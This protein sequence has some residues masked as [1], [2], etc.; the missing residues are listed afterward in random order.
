MR[1]TPPS[2][3]K[4]SKPGVSHDQHHRQKIDGSYHSGDKVDEEQPAVSGVDDSRDETAPAGHA[5]DDE[6]VVRLHLRRLYRLQTAE[7]VK[8]VSRQFV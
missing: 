8:H 7:K 2:K 5:E 3:H 1:D 6:V 4:Q